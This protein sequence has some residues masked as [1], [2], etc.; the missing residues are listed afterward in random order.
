MFRTKEKCINAGAWGIVMLLIIMAFLLV[1]K[2]SAQNPI[3]YYTGDNVANPPGKVK[4]EM[5]N[6]D[7]TPTGSFNIV[8]G[9]A[10]G[11]GIEFTSATDQVAASTTQL[12]TASFTFE[13]LWKPGHY[14]DNC[15][16]GYQYDNAFSCGIQVMPHSDFAIPQINFFTQT[17]S[18][19][20]AHDLIVQLDGVGR[21]SLGWF[22]DGNYHHM[23]FKYNSTTGLKQIFVDGECPA[24]FSETVPTGNLNTFDPFHGFWFNSTVSYVKYY[25]Y[26][27]NI[28][29]YDQAIPAEQI[30]QHYL[31]FQAGNNYSFTSNAST[32]PVSVITSALDPLDYVAGTSLNAGQPVTP[33]ASCPSPLNQLKAYPLPRYHIEAPMLK[34]FQWFDPTYLAGN[35]Q[36]GQTPATV[37]TYVNQQRELYNNWNYYVMANPNVQSSPNYNN[38]TT[39]FVPA[40]AKLCKD[41]PTWKCSAITFRVQGTGQSIWSIGHAD[42]Q[43]LSDGANFVNLSCVDD[44][45]KYWSPAGNSMVYKQD[46]FDMRSNLQALVAAISPNKLKI[47]NEN[48][49]YLPLIPPATLN[50]DPRCSTAIA[51]SGLS[52]TTWLGKR[53]FDVSSASYRNIFMA[54]PELKGTWFTEYAIDGKVDPLGVPDYRIDYA[55]MRAMNSPIKGLRYP[56]ADYYPRWPG[57]WRNW[58]SAWHGWEWM[59]QCK[60]YEI[61]N[62]D[63][64]SSPFVCAGF[65][66]IEENTI[67]PA[68]FLGGLKCLAASGSEFFYSG[69]FTLSAPY[70]EPKNW[71]WQIAIP[72]YVQAITSRYWDLFKNGTLQD[73]DAPRTWVNDPPQPGYSYYTGDPRKLCVVRKHAS[74]NKYVI[75][76]C[77]NPVTNELGQVEDVSNSTIYL[78]T[79]TLTFETRRQGSVY[80]YDKTVSPPAFYQLDKW[81]EATHP[82]RWTADFE[83]EAE[84]WDNS[85]DSVRFRT[86][87]G[88]VGKDYSSFTTVA[89]TIAKKY[90][91]RYDFQPRG[92]VN[93]TYYVWIK[94]AT[95]SPGTIRLR[96][97]LDDGS[98]QYMDI[99]GTTLAWYSIR[100]TGG[101]MSFSGVTPAKH[102]LKIYQQTQGMLVDKVALTSD[103]LK[104]FTN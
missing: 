5:G 63:P 79:D 40:G 99:T 30:Y 3:R 25:G 96:V 45:S 44:G 65:D 51:Q 100:T 47:I 10:I 69:Y 1:K 31:D 60:G 29:I 81:H 26:F 64:F 28:A 23:A 52:A 21:K 80:I 77:L 59:V 34:N 104:S 27:D 6:Y 74:K 46:G 95:S 68:Q 2:V 54:L 71:C 32:A 83:F 49:E 102:S 4:D 8:N 57:N 62:G 56:T 88:N 61:A 93:K 72:S 9:G 19:N 66:K 101:P 18:P 33:C 67:R 39:E 35:G 14:M 48:A 75:A 70:N 92:V 15:Y 73:G 94:A 22:F 41:N 76:S 38:Y 85:D 16:F 98:T 84:C 91:L 97:S 50:C 12:L 89:G 13:F 20:E 78:G 90:P 42:E 55:S 53:A 43:Y 86:T 58:S 7:L 17:G 103:P 11:K 24:G 82:S 36:D 37:A 87:T